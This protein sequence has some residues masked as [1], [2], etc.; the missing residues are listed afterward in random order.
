MPGMLT[1]SDQI[2]EYLS[3]PFSGYDALIIPTAPS[4]PLLKWSTSLPDYS[5]FALY[6]QTWFAIKGDD[7]GIPP[8]WVP[9]QSNT[10]LYSIPSGHQTD[11][12]HPS[13]QTLLSASVDTRN[14]LVSPYG[15]TRYYA[16]QGEQRK[17]LLAELERFTKHK[18][19]E[20]QI[21]YQHLL[22]HLEIKY[23]RVPWHIL[24]EDLYRALL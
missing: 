18:S 15:L 13:P 10:F 8:F 11:T 4:L 1:E 17:V 5:G 24:T 21:D 7:E 6:N 3:Q 23:H 22:K 20:V 2:R 14:F 16:A 12:S 19:P 9:R